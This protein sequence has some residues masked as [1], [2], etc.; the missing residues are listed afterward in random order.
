[1][2]NEVITNENMQQLIETGKVDDF[3]LPEQIAV[4][5]PEV[6]AADAESTEEAADKQAPE[7]ESEDGLEAEDAQLTERARKRIGKKHRQMKEAE[8]F[9]ES[10]YNERRMAE[11]R[12]EEL[13]R[14]N[15]E[16]KSKLSPPAEKVT[17]PKEP[18]P[19]DFTNDKGEFDAFGYA[20]ALAKHAATEAVAEDRAKQAS[21]RKAEEAR[22]AD[23]AFRGR[24]Q[25]FAKSQ[26]D[27]A[28]LIEDVE[29]S[30]MRIATHLGAYITD[31]DAGP[32]LLFHLMKH[33][34]VLERLN[35][36]SPIKAIAEI[37]KLETKLEKP[38]ANSGTPSI[39][40]RP[41]APAPIK[42]IDGS[43]TPVNKNPADMTFEELRIYNAAQ[44]AAQRRKN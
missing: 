7:S 39:P 16:L 40:E 38:V 33:P 30:E 37:G 1:M 25:A 5:E 2:S 24:L 22:K 4:G 28:T 34:D 42:P 8:E 31:A 23:E 11:K 43:S 36:L 41:R 19:K 12:A 10:Q 3:K 13:A 9:A 21:E 20:K 35:S 32:Q 29:A 6:A 14:E 44:R 27:A 15:A 26:P 17:E 18:D